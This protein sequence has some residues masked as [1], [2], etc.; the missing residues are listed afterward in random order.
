MKKKSAMLT[1]VSLLL[2]AGSA[3]AAGNAAL[4]KGYEKWEKS[5][6]KVVT[7]KSSLFYGV[8]YIYVDKKAMPAYK[9]GGKYPEG[10]RFVVDYYKMKEEN[11]KP[12][13]GK[14][15]M[16]VLMKKDKKFKET[17]GWQFAGFTAEGKPSKLDPVTN[18]YECHLKEARD[19]DYVIS[20]YADFK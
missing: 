9:A 13:K 19:R 8:H 15:N 3:W 10:S 11:G 2:A 1:A 18:C 4:P 16:I 12:V 6:E 17:G 14:K 20:R 5:K 7:D